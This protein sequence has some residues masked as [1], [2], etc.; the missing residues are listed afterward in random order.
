MVVELIVEGA[1]SL[2]RAEAKHVKADGAKRNELEVEVVSHEEVEKL[3]VGRHVDQGQG[4]KEDDLKRPDHA[5]KLAHHQTTRPLI[6][7]RSLQEQL[8]NRA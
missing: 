2:F 5:P 8:K 1:L 7:I 6:S 3:D 4:K